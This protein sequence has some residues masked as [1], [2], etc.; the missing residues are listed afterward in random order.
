ME[1]EEAVVGDV[2]KGPDNLL[3]TVQS[4]LKLARVPVYLTTATS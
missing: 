2:G 4:I 1:L 3:N